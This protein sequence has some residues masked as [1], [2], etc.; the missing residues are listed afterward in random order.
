MTAS[1]TPEPA[2]GKPAAERP[3]IDLA[4]LF[5]PRSVAIVGASPR[6][7]IAQTVR[8]NLLTMGSATTCYF[9]NPKYEEAWGS[10]CYPDLAAL[11]EVPDSVLVA[12]NPLRAASVTEDAARAGA[13]SVLIPGGGV[14]EGGE[15]AARM[16]REVREI[17]LRHGLAILGPNCMG[18]ID[19]ISNSAVYI[20]DINPWAPRGHVAGIAQSGSVTDAFIHFGTRI[21]FS[22]IIGAGSEVILDVCDYLGYCLDDPETDAVILFV[23][24]FKRPERFLALADRALALGKPIIA[25]K[26]GRS[27]QAQ[28]AA[29]AHSGSLAG[30]TR[31]TDAALAAAGVVRCNDLDALFEAAELHAGCRRTGR[32]VG[33]GR[34]GIVT[35]STGEASLI[36]DI[37]QRTGTDLPPVPDVARAAILE[38]LP[39]LGYIG[40][41]IDPWGATDE[42]VAY[43]VVLEAFAASGGY[44]V[45]A[46]VHD[47]PYRSLPSEVAVAEGVAQALIA[48]TARRPA[49][50]P[51]YL[52]LTS[53]E[54]TPEI[55][56]MLDAAGGIPCLRGTTEA[57][58]AIAGRAAW[59]AA[60]AAR[61]ADGPRR[62]GW[63]ELGAD[64][65]PLGHDDAQ[66]HRPAAGPQTL[67][68]RE[69]LA[70]LAGAG[71]AMVE[72]RFV[73]D[74]AGAVEA[75]AALG[76]PVV[77]KLDA[78]GA[79]HKTELGGVRLGL[80]G[81]EAIQA[82][83][84]ELLAIGRRAEVGLRGLLVERQV[85]PGL[86]L[87]V[88]MKRDPQFGPIVLVGLGGILAEA[89]DDVAFELAPISEA[90]ADAMLDRL[91]SASLLAGTRGRPAVDRA[92]VARLVAALSELA[93]QRPELLEIDLN[94][95]IASAHGVSA[96]DALVV[97]ATVA[98]GA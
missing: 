9:V 35:V 15:A 91:R 93:W 83:A 76:G 74:A 96:V 75:A 47:F 69:S 58:A 52:S 63:L 19:R 24:G 31:A 48:A 14:V 64:R 13:R 45:L 12:V 81:R 6:S 51:V 32:G 41:P 17:A 30:E 54:P 21:G 37:A 1:S 10:P 36:A 82:A 8:D 78:T 60:R 46:I 90:I 59:E 7:D 25:L 65:T 66:P 34:T 20:G 57:L 39:T 87:I 5:A 56:A 70:L 55:V 40:N 97:R 11:P 23:E 68:E 16:Q 29:V 88:G 84:E 28:A 49:V 43:P 42:H 79:A 89:F 33:R 53:G 71:L 4:A 73:T 38:Q 44:D 50:L 67:P 62:P 98:A 86:E 95:V 27:P 18:M 22:R 61:L 26:V 2:Q 92:G 72:A 77:L 3:P 80:T 94:P 85:D